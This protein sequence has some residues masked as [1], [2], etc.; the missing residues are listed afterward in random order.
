MGRGGRACEH[1]QVGSSSVPRALHLAAAWAWRGLV[2]AAAAYAAVR[3]AAELRLVVLP[4][5]LALFLLTVLWPAAALLRRHRVPAAPAALLVIGGFLA[6]VAALVAVIGPTVAGQADDLGRDLGAGF[7]QLG[8]WLAREPF[9]GAAPDL[10]RSLDAALDYARE[11]A[12]IISGGLLT[13]V[14][15][16]VELVAG[17]LLALVATFF[18]LKDGESMRDWA[19]GTLAPGRRDAASELGQK[20][21]IALGGYVRGLVVVALFDAVVIGLALVAI[22]VPLVLPLAVLTFFGA[23]VP[24][25]GAFA[26]G[27]AAALVA[28]VAGGIGDAV[29]VVVAITVIQQVESQLLYPVVIG[30]SLRLHPLPIL[31][32][33]TAGGVLYGIV[34]AALGAPAL[35]AAATVASF[36]RERHRL[37]D[38]PPRVQLAG[39]KR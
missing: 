24:I 3:A 16:A 10:D 25:V 22:G 1:G 5:L 31:L 18:L 21:W 2:V 15:L 32:A 28:L 8:R 39:P 23:F 26:A 7:D 34:G 13:G 37:E 17:L 11:N 30:R 14:A 29:L 9:G 33:V 38:P 6:A 35:A 36:A 20:L 12:T 19:I 4:T 27:L